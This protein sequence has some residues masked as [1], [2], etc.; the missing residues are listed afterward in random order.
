MTNDV[1]LRRGYDLLACCIELEAP[2]FSFD[3]RL[4]QVLN[5]ASSE[6]SYS[7]TRMINKVSP[8]LA[9]WT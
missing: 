1:F 9:L 5:H 4:Y 3:K 2:S 8:N 6:H 7:N